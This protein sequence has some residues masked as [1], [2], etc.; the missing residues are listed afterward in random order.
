MP[1][2]IRDSVEGYYSDTRMQL[3]YTVSAKVTRSVENAGTALPVAV[4]MVALAMEC[5][6]QWVPQS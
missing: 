4:T 5:F 1:G 3:S 2:G 6:I